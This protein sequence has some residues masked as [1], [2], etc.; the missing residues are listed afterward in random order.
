M[1]GETYVTYLMFLGL[2]IIM[3]IGADDIFVIFNA[4]EHS[5]GAV[6]R[7][8]QVRVRVSVWVGLG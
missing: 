5:E 6:S 8:E 1:I 2:F 3:G 7:L 4:W